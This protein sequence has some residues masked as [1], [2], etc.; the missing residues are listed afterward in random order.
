M[1]RQVVELLRRYGRHDVLW[2]HVPNGFKG[3]PRQWA[4]MKALGALP[5]A[6][7]LCLVVDGKLVF[8]ELKREGEG[9]REEQREFAKRAA[10]A[11][12]S[13][14]VADNYQAAARLLQDI[15][16]FRVRLAALEEEQT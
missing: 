7:D 8:L 14:H 12:A 15:G 10:L 9:P 4:R 5:G 3:D 1:H 16:M 13:Y 2:F 6:P 11:G